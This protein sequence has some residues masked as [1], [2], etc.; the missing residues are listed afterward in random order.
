MK[1]SQVLE[2]SQDTVSKLDSIEK[3]FSK[4]GSFKEVYPNEYKMIHHVRKENY[5]Y[6]RGGKNWYGVLLILKDKYYKQIGR[7]FLE[8]IKDLEICKDNHA[9]VERNNLIVKILIPED[10]GD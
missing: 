8:I 5:R 2:A 7:D 6:S 1:F 4:K 10:R 3:Y 9:R